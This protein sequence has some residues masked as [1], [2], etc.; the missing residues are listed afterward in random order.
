MSKNILVSIINLTYNHE[1]YIRQCLDGFVMQKTGFAFEVLIHDDAS[2]DNTANIIREYEEKYPDIIKPIYQPENR[3]SKGLPIT[4]I[5]NLPRAKGKYIAMCEGDDYWTD[6][7]KLQKQV[8]FLEANEDYGL[9]YTD[10]KQYYQSLGEFREA[11]SSSVQSLEDLITDVGWVPTLTTCFRKDLLEDYFD[12][13]LPQ[14]PELPFG[15]YPM[16]MY[17]LTKTKIYYLPEIT[18][19]YRVLDNSACHFTDIEEEIRFKKKSYECRLFFQQKFFPKECSLVKKIKHN[20]ALRI[21]NPCI[22]KNSKKCF[23]ENSELIKD[24]DNFVLR[25]CYTLCKVNFTVFSF[26]FRWLNNFRRWIMRIQN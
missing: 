15:D 22:V 7:L 25:Q 3:Y 17:F 21:L 6:P 16:W 14:V 4:P 5:F 19:V 20:N 10:T 11:K 24:V 8:D 26:V 23:L 1:P 18:G 12:N 13:F 9:V 2:T